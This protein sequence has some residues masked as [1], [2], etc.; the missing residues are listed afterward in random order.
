[1]IINSIQNFFV[2]RD[3]ALIILEKAKSNLH[4]I[5][6]VCRN[7]KDCSDDEELRSRIRPPQAFGSQEWEEYIGV[8]AGKEL[9]L[10]RRIY[11]KEGNCYLT[12]IPEKVKAIKENEKIEEIFLDNLET[13]GNLVAN[14]KKGNKIGF[15]HGDWDSCLVALQDKRKLKKPHWVLIGKE[16]LGRSKTYQ[17]QREYAKEKKGKISGLIDTV[18]SIF[19]EYVRSGERNFIWDRHVKGIRT[20]I[21]VKDKSKYESDYMRLGLGFVPSGLYVNRYYGDRSGRSVAFVFSRKS[22]IVQPKT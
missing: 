5:S 7:W 16:A 17:E 22:R 4:G 6:E 2:P 11:S 12:F 10:P 19:M 1:M 9:P 15:S 3:I 18:V 8:D 21:R 13:I 20:W 14:P